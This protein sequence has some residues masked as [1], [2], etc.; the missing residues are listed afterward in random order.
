[1]TTANVV[2][3][4]TAGSNITIA[5]DGTISTVSAFETVSRNLNSKPF[6]MSRSGG[7]LQSITYDLGGGQS[8]TKTLTRVNGTLSS[9][10]LSG[11][12]P[13]GIDLVKALQRDSGGNLTGVTYG[14]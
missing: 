1:M 5:S 7:V 12:T 14:V 10:T 2:S 11:D 8:I 6:T 3:A 9:V 4:L 13:S